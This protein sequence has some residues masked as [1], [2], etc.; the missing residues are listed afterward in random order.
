MADIKIRKK[1]IIKSFDNVISKEKRIKHKVLEIKNKTN[2]NISKEENNFEMEYAT[3]KITDVVKEGTN[4]INK[5][6]VIGEKSFKQTEKNIKTIKQRIN[7]INQK[8]TSLK[9]EK[10]QVQNFDLK[11]NIGINKNKSLIKKAENT[12]IKMIKTTKIMP[13]KEKNINI[14]NSKIIRNKREIINNTINNTKA[15]IKK[16]IE[17]IGKTIKVSKGIIYA[18]IGGG[19]IVIIIVLIFA[20]IG[21]FISV[22]FNSNGD[23]DYSV[24]EVPSSQIV[25]VAK[26]QIGNEGGD[27]FWKWYGFDEHVHWC[28]CYVSWCANECGYIEKGIIPKFSVCTDGIKWFQEHNEWHNREEDYYAIIGDIIFFD[29]YDDDGNQDGNS[30]HVGIVTRTDIVNRMVYT[31]EGNTN[32][33][34]AERMYSLDD[35]QIMGYGNPKY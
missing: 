9:V 31:I 35:V 2:E 20:L 11:T 13:K 33:Q 8:E 12:N 10:G 30:D 24:L 28:A 22:I 14:V 29:W 7:Y 26:A 21:G 25:L 15:V 4:N 27:K 5:I 23:T 6:N 17:S 3:N 19:W 1:G 32:N 18:L 34:C 16:I